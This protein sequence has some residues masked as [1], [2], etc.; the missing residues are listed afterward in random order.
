[1]SDDCLNEVRSINFSDLIANGNTASIHLID[2]KVY[3]IFNKNLPS[4]EAIREARKQRYAYASGLRVPQVFDVVEMNGQQCIVMEHIQG[5]TLGELAFEEMNQMESYLRTSVGVQQQIH[6]VKADFIDPML[7]KLQRQIESADFLNHIQKEALVKRL[8]DLSGESQLCHGDF[9]FYNLISSNN[10]IVILDWID[11]S[12][13]NPAAD[14]YRS[15]LLYTQVSDQIAELYLN[16]YCETSSIPRDEIIEWAPVIAGARLSE[17]VQS[18][19]PERLLEIV[20]R[21]C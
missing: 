6:L 13:G 15:Y 19:S 8:S 20:N 9:H 5:R 18:E 21:F 12:A 7:F 2:H 11:A 10:E 1:M 4:D 14:V 16:L 17:H 3:K